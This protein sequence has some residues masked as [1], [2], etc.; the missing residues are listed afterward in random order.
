MESE[1]DLML[2]IKNVGSI[3]T[4]PVAVIEFVDSKVANLFEF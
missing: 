4:F 2:E 1:T 3:T